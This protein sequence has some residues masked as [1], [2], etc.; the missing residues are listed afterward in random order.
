LITFKVEHFRDE[1][2]ATQ[3]FKSVADIFYEHQ[4]ELG[5]VNNLAEAFAVNVG[6]SWQNGGARFVVAYDGQKPI[7]AMWWVSGKSFISGKSYANLQAIHVLKSHRASGTAK[8]MLDFGVEAMKAIGYEKILA[9]IDV[10][11]R[12][13]KWV[14]A[15]SRKVIQEV[16]EL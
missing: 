4:Q 12:G 13:S 3:L 14:K 7:G 8:Q 16:V 10:D 11:S 1:E 9:T 2:Q 15:N 5:R 6:P